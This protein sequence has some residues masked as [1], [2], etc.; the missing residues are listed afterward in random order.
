MLW[1]IRVTVHAFAGAGSP[2]SPKPGGFGAAKP[3]GFGAQPLGGPGLGGHGARACWGDLFTI[4]VLAHPF[5]TDITRVDARAVHA[6]AG[7][8]SPG[9]PKPG[10]FGAKPGGFGAKPGGFGSGG[11]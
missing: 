8:G 11:A 3:G 7:T 2:G 1:R 10:G 4:F 6:F 5:T 9:S